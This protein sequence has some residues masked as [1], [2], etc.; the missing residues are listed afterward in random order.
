MIRTKLVEL[1]EMPT[2]LDWTDEVSRPVSI[3]IQNLA[4]EGYVYIGHS[5]VSN[6]DFGVRIPPEGTFDLDLSDDNVYASTNGE[7][8]TISVMSLDI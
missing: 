3:V 7:S 1:S 5:A 6:S 8:I 2:Q 4:D